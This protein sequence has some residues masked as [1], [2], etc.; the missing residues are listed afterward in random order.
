[1]TPGD[2]T[3]YMRA[4]TKCFR[5]RFVGVSTAG[6]VRHFKKYQKWLEYRS[7]IAPGRRIRWR[8]ND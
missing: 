2:N 8:N 1:M 5:T 3:L 6:F 4:W 7:L